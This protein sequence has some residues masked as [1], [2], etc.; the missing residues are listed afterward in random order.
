MSVDTKI[1][2]KSENIKPKI[3]CRILNSKAELLSGELSDAINA[4]VEERGVLVWNGRG[5]I[6]VSFHGYNE[7]RD[8]AWALAALKGV[9]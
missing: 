3:G 2:L 8:V 7:E 4:A 1:Q 6:R 9:F 5:R